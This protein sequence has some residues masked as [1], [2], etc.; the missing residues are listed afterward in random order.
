MLK[1]KC[2]RTFAQ[3]SIVRVNIVF[4][5]FTCL[6]VEWLHYKWSLLIL[7]S[8]TEGGRGKKA[9][10]HIIG[11]IAHKPTQFQTCQ[12]SENFV[13]YGHNKKM[14]ALYA[15]AP[16]FVLSLELT[17]LKL[18]GSS[19]GINPSTFVLKGYYM[20]NPPL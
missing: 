8:P 9:F 5:L 3:A 18:Q 4:F 2:F 16:K 14:I 10:T 11:L 15:L 6:K 19:F 1:T 7:F 20:M 13:R 17:L 12:W